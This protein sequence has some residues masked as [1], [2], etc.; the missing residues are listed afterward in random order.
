MSEIAEEFVNDKDMSSSIYNSVLD[1]TA[2]FVN[3]RSRQFSIFDMLGQSSRELTHS[4]FIAQ[5][6]NPKGTH[7]V[8]ALF[9]NIFLAHLPVKFDFLTDDADVE[10]EKDYGPKTGKGEGSRGGRI[11]IFL[12]DSYGRIIAIENKIYA[13]DQEDQLQRYSNSISEE[14][15]EYLIL[16]LTLDGRKPSNCSGTVKYHQISYKHTIKRWL[17]D[18]QKALD[19]T[20]PLHNIITQYMTTI[21]TLISDQQ[22]IGILSQSSH[23]LKASLQ[24]A[25]L[26]GTARQN[27]KERFLKILGESF[28]QGN[29][30][31]KQDGKELILTT[32]GCD[33][34]IE[35]NL[36]IRFRN[37]DYEKITLWRKK[38]MQSTEDGTDWIYVLLGQDKINFQDYNKNASLWLDAPDDF[39]EKF[40]DVFLDIRKNFG[41]KYS[42]DMEIAARLQS[43]V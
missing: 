38:H 36:F 24:I 42:F 25:R 12:R 34:C 21:N 9:L 2:Q 15:N 20:H 10:I 39:W 6:L 22:V 5:M 37:P 23:N 16:Y 1:N 3:E 40:E 26:A 41:L 32:D 8:G 14:S 17:E 18:C 13:T 19:A 30:E 7:E 27:L 11:D 4:A 33:W 29:T 28:G 43:S 31:V 35:H